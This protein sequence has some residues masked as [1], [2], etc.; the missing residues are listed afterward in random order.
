MKRYIMMLMLAVP[1]SGITQPIPSTSSTPQHLS[2]AST[3]SI[4]VESAEQ[5]RQRLLAAIGD[6]AA[7]AKAGGYHVRATHYLAD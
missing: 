3:P 6:Q 2:D 5:L 7:W 1:T 4:A